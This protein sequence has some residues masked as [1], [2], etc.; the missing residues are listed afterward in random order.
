MWISVKEHI[1]EEREFSLLTQNC[2]SGRVTLQFIRRDT[3][4]SFLLL[5]K[6]VTELICC[7]T[8]KRIRRSDWTTEIKETAEEMKSSL[9][10]PH[11]GYWSIGVIALTILL[12]VSIGFYS[13]IKSSDAYQDSFMAQNDQQKKIILQ[14]LDVGDLISTMKKVYKIQAVNDKNVIL[15]ESKN[16]IPEHFT[17]GLTNEAYPKTSFTNNKLEVPNAVFINGMISSTDMILNILDN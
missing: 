9:K 15:V 11:W 6:K 1:I 17:E 5:P 13:E 8:G 10:V 3:K 2:S 14:K 12:A 16:P 4:V 7:D